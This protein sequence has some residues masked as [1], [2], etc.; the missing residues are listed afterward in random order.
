MRPVRQPT[1]P[2]GWFGKAS[3]AGPP[4]GGLL[5]GGMLREVLEG[6]SG[7]DAT[8]RAVNELVPVL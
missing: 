3:L 2:A 4:G 8:C 5:M 7:F 6:R 1:G